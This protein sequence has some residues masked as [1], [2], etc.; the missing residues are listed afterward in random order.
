VTPFKKRLLSAILAGPL[1]ALL[2]YFLPPALFLFFLVLVLLGAL[3]EFASL[4]GIEGKIPALVLSLFALLPLYG[5]SLP[6]FLLWLFSSAALY[7]ILVIA[8]QNKKG[9]EIN[10]KTA[11]TLAVLLLS[12][13][14]LVLPFFFLYRLKVLNN[15]FP[16]ILLLTLWASD[17]SAYLVGRSFG[18]RRLVPSI[19]P[20]KT[21][22]GL[23]GAL[24]GSTL[25]LLLFSRSLSMG[26]L[27]SCA[28]GL[29]IGLL[30]QL[31][32]IL[33]SIG[34]RVCGAK[35]SSSIIPGH[36]GILDRMDSFLFTSPFFYHYL[37]VMRG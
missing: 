4:T 21:V 3:Y 24:M 36:G 30:G 2:F 25:V 13:V 22:E 33:E 35:D 37:A 11:R 7:L 34:K 6:G 12:E 20:G 19:S 9:K 15:L 29:A 14:F 16:L 26:L 18:K 23:M 28:V 8:L 5:G 10:E 1:V 31:G 27:E 32:D 17:T